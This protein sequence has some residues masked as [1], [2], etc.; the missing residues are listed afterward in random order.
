MCDPT[1]IIGGLAS[2]YGAYDTRRAQQ[3]AVKK[4]RG[5]NLLAQEENR[6]TNQQIFNKADEQINQYAP[7]NLAQ[8]IEDN[9]Q[10]RETGA[11]QAI[12]EATNTRSDIASKTSGI[13]SDDYKR[14]EAS[15]TA[16]SLSRLLENAKQN[17]RI[18]GTSDAHRELGFGLH[19][20]G[21]EVRQLVNA[22][23]NVQ[24]IY[25]QQV[26]AVTPNPSFL[27][28]LA[29]QAGGSIISHAAGGGLGDLFGKANKAA[30]VPSGHGFAF[31]QAYPSLYPTNPNKGG[32][33]FGK[34]Y[35]A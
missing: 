15:E 16:Y 3:K 19:D 35:G 2:A 4:Q 18:G 26:A 17:A 25:R 23:D 29:N 14:K 28:Q 1:L 6:R 12:E 20:A 33:I 22:N 5:I 24:S 7:G 32:Y 27:G 9:T 31:G 10:S 34:K 21:R 11:L 13:I 8:V 30:A